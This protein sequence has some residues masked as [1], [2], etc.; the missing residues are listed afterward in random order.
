MASRQ[1][2]NGERALQ[3]QACLEGMHEE[4]GHWRGRGAAFNRRRLRRE[5]FTILCGCDCHA[6]CPV[7]SEKSTAAWR[8][9]CTCPGTDAIRRMLDE[10][11][12][13]PFDI[14][15]SAEMWAK[16]RREFKSRREA[17]GAARTGAPGQDREH[18]KDLYA[19][20]L[21]SRG[22]KI[23]EGQALDAAIGAHL[24]GYPAGARLA[25]QEVVSLGKRLGSFRHP[26]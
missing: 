4:C 12:A 15:E 9:S 26:R 24:D 7:T 2:G 19:A 25:G 8:Q 21:R 20:E 6:S 5:E 17:F 11:P 14:R 18:L 16:S 10:L 13:Q 1:V 3:G 22:L 23:P